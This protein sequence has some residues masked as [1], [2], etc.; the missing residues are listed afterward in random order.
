L[1]FLGIDI[2][3]DHHDV[4]M[5]DDTGEIIH[6]HL[7]IDN[8]KTGLKRLHTA[9]QARMKSV[10][11]IHIGMEETGIYHENI[12]DFL[13]AKGYSVYTIN[14]KLT[15]H[16]RLSTSPRRTKTDRLDAMAICRYVMN[17]VTVLHPYTP[18]LYY[19]DE[20]KQLARNYELKKTQRSKTKT[21]LKR[22]LQISFPEFLKHF[23]PYANW[24]LDV[25][26]EY[27]VPSDYKGLHTMPL[28]NRIKTKSNRYD[29]A[30]LL[31]QIA[32]DSI[33]RCD[34]LQSHLIRCAIDDLNHYDQQIKELKKLIV[35]KVSV[36][37]QLLSVPG[38]GPIN[39]AIIIGETGD[40][41]RFSNK[42]EYYAFYGCDPVIHESGNYKLRNSHLSKTGNK[43]LRT[44]IYSAARVACVGVNTKDNKF[45]R[46]YLA[47]TAKNNKHH[48]T[49]IFAI[50]KNMVH[51]IYVI[52]RDSMYYDD[53]K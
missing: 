16:S 28:A 14:P 1:V 23:D 38:I 31:K 52:L 37:P 41:D 32:R 17:S 19:I 24:A 34:E 33:G 26:R 18:S 2:A 44:A 22:L 47:M 45:Q 25:L 36:F 5:V 20:L 13:I 30:V 11:D 50:A 8:D 21:E 42:H 10:T 7:R 15:Y 48:N 3:K 43:Y 35:R 53:T 46:K 27:P 4:A 40:I 29:N 9:I 51:T 39:A 12:R 6:P 49:I